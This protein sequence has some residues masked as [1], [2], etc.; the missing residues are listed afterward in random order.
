MNINTLTFFQ[1]L[2]WFKQGWE[3]FMHAPIQWVLMLLVFFAL[4]IVLNFIPFI[5]PLALLIITPALWAGLFICADKANKQENF[6]VMDL[7]SVL[8]DSSIRNPFLILGGISILFQITIWLLGMAGMLAGSHVGAMTTDGQMAGSDMGVLALSGGMSIFGILLV[9]IIAITYTLAMVYAIPLL[10]FSKI[11]I[12]DALL[13]S[14]KAGFSNIVP[15]LLAGIIF[16][17]LIF[18]AMIPLG[19]GFLVLVPVS[20]GAVY[21]S[22]LDIFDT[23]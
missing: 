20:I 8:Q 7:F 18:I 4:S 9:L 13:L 19:L 2:Q 15:M 12:K 5:G 16:F 3:I 6:K 22:Y 21:T 14:L 1:P 10:L 17:I 11:G 23:P